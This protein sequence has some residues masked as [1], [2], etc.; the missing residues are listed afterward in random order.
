MNLVVVY[1]DQIEVIE[2][3]PLKSC[4][5]LVKGNILRERVSF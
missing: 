5:L 1:L 3:N 2:I 4:Y